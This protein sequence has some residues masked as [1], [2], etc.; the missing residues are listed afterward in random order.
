MSTPNT[1][2]PLPA[3]RSQRQHRVLLALL[4]GSKTREQLDRIAGA[5]NSPDV[6]YRL[7]LRFG[8]ELPCRLETITDMDSKP[9][10]RGVYSL[11]EQDAQK[12]RQL[13]QAN[14]AK[15]LQRV[16]RGTP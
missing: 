15:T 8:L 6:V 3:M 2:T 7:R 16:D 4:T 10:E 9:V 1:S 12:A 14:A 5:S 13:V 11:T